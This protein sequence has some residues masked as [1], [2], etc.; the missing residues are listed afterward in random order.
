MAY[1]VTKL[2]TN[3]WYLSG[4]VSRDLE[5]VSGDQISDGLDLL[6]AVLAIKTANRRLI[7]YFT[8]YMLN[9][10][11][12]QEVYFIPNLINA[13]TL[14]FNIGPVRYSMQWL[15]RKKYF[16]TG[17][18]DNISSLP[19]D[20]HVERTKGGAN[21]YLYFLPDSN[22]PLIIWGKFSLAM[23]TNLQQDLSLTL[24]AF[25]IEYLRYALAEY[26]CSE[27][28][29]NL[30]PQSQQKLNEYEEIITDISPID[31]SVSKTSTL[32]R[33]QGL[34]WGDI[35]IGRGWRPS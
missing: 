9:A 12:N 7:P 23:L 21:L 17:R 25:Y 31:L 27:Y 33:H 35:N 29:I 5:T 34:N 16:G 14:T 1:T 13:E 18:V 20:W 15:D 19:F 10:V 3:A 32:Q 4:I 2:I 6:N 11:P 8:Q 26:M 28:N 24:D 30:Q 22:Y